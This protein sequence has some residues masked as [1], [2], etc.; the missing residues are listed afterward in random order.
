LQAG[1]IILRVQQQ[2]VRTPE[3]AEAALKSRAAA[4]QPYAAILAERD[5]KPNW[6]P[7][8]LPGE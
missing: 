8:T 4:K 1:D 3:E 7:I 2:R 6:I 5:G